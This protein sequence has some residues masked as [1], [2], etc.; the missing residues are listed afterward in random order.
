MFLI[1]CLQKMQ[2]ETLG[3]LYTIEQGE[4]L[5]DLAVLHIAVFLSCLSW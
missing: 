3:Y 2:G 5:E 4:I 1:V